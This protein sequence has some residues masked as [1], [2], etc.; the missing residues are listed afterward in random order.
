MVSKAAEEGMLQPLAR[1]VLQYRISLYADNVVLFLCPEA[2]DI[3][4]TMDILR[5]FG[6][7]SGLK[8]NLQQRMYFPSDVRTITWRLYSSNSHVRWLI[9]HANIWLFHLP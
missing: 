7:A 6:V 8:T 1:R 5:L 2:A 3:A 4:I 9:S